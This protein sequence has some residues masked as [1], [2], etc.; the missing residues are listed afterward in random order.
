M[1][2]RP[3]LVPSPPW[4]GRRVVLAVTGGIACY[5]SVTLA[6]DLTRLGRRGRRSLS[7]GASAF[8]RPLVFEGVTGDRCWTRSGPRRAPHGTFGWPGRRT[9]SWWRRR[10]RT[11]WPG[12]A[13]GRAEDLITTVLLATRAPVLLAPAMNDRMWDHP[14]PVGT[15][16]LQEVLG[17]RLL[18]PD[19]PWRWARGRGRGGWWNPR[20]SSPEQVGPLLGRPAPLDRPPGA[21]HGGSRPGKPGGRRALPGEPVV[22]AH[23]VAL[24]REAWLRGADVTLAET[25]DA[26]G[27][28]R[29]EPGGPRDGGGR[30]ARSERGSDRAPLRGGGGKLLDLLLASV[31]LSRGIRSTSAT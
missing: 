10:R 20:R 9:W 27:L 25:A 14:R 19:G 24:A 16:H 7:E 3:V 11:S 21:R 15:P 8:L 23:G 31:G 2:A 13:Q 18:G 22:R 12:A 1:T 28:L 4:E 29:R 5:K 6:R 17:Y 26:G 30:G